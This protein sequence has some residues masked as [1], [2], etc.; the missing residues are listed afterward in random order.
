MGNGWLGDA[1]GSMPVDSGKP[2][3][4]HVGDDSLPLAL[5][6]RRVEEN[7]LLGTDHGTAGPVL[8]AGTHF[9]ERSY[10][11][12]PSLTDLEDGDLK[13]NLDFR[14]LYSAIV[15]GWL[16]PVTDSMPREFAETL[17]AF[18]FCRT[19]SRRSGDLPNTA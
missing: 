16:E 19:Q 1:F 17:I 18:L 13:L 7:D 3:A 10:G 9:A 12:L 2:Q 6:G 11:Q 14:Q 5:V 15:T 8:L 4:I